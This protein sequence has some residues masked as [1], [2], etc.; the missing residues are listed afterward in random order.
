MQEICGKITR[1]GAILFP[2]TSKGAA[3]GQTS[4][5]PAQVPAQASCNEFQART[6]HQVATIEKSKTS[7]DKEDTIIEETRTDSTPKA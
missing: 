2:P 4:K 5:S 3:W 1:W 6:S 7:A